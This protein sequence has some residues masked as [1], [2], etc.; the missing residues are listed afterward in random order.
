MEIA[1]EEKVELDPSFTDLN[2]DDYPSLEE[3]VSGVSDDGDADE[4]D[5]PIETDEPPAEATPAEKAA[6]S[7]TAAQAKVDAKGNRHRPEDGKFDGRAEQ[8]PVG[9]E[10]PQ[11][12]G[13]EPSGEPVQT[14]KTP[15]QFRAD[16]QAFQFPGSEVD[17]EWIRI[18]RTHEADLRTLLAEGV[19]HRG[20]H[21]K[22]LTVASQQRQAAEKRAILAESEA[23]KARAFLTHLTDLQKK[24]PEAVAEWLDELDRN[25]PALEAKA[26][27]RQTAYMLEQAKA[28]LDQPAAR[29][30]QP[31]AE[32]G[33]QGGG[34]RF[35]YDSTQL[36]PNLV[37]NFADW[38]DQ[39]PELNT[40]LNEDDLR[41]LA[42]DLEPHLDS[43]YAVALDDDVEAGYTKG[44]VLI[45]QSIARQHLKRR[46]AQKRRL[47][48]MNTEANKAAEANARRTGAG[49]QGA[50]P[51]VAGKGSSGK[52]PAKGMFV[53]KLPKLGD[54]AAMDRWLED[55]TLDQQL[56]SKAAGIRET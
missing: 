54:K 41:E 28:R 1:N 6:Q 55:Y 4:D 29:E 8:A 22:Q 2:D 50:P 20:S 52:A 5:D 16:Q 18:P 11:L 44:D 21:R 25:M 19:A 34:Q 43:I 9:D 12:E 14:Q 53:P 48:G 10:E 27:Q 23:V 15:F 56:A 51:A 38:V 17:D 40:L 30:E 7:K 31:A 13:E 3:D 36:I 49:Q 35:E 47:L 32:R 45:R 46:A 24:G 26:V 33:A 42:E 37:A 39:D